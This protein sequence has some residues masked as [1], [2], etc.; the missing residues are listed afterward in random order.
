LTNVPARVAAAGTLV[1]IAMAVSSVMSVSAKDP[2]NPNGSH[3]GLINNPGHHYGQLKHNQ[4][5]PTPDPQPVPAPNTQPGTAPATHGSGANTGN[6]VQAGISLSI[7]N[8]SVTAAQ[9]LHPAVR[10]GRA[11]SWE[12][13]GGLDGLILLVLPLLLAVWIIV[14]GRM[15][16]NA[17]RGGRRARA[18]VARAY[19]T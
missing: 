3:D 15:V 10:L 13:Q 18:R 5:P 9:G 14:A 12:P 7:P 8:L 4:P 6:T 11:A 1:L 2:D 19:G 17:M 16:D